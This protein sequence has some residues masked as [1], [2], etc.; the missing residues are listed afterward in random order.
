MSIDLIDWLDVDVL[1]F[2]LRSCWVNRSRINTLGQSDLEV[3]LSLGFGKKMSPFSCITIFYE[4]FF[5]KCF[6]GVYSDIQ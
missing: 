3:S 4:T 5:L 1:I 6:L 2:F